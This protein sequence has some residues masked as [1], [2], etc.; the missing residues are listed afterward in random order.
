MIMQRFRILSIFLILA[1]LISLQTTA[2]RIVKNYEKEWVQVDAF[3]KR[4][5]PKSALTQVKK[6]Y[7]L[8]KKEKQ[9]AQIIK[10]LVYMTGLQEQVTENGGVNS[11]DDIEKEISTATEPAKSILNSMLADMYWNYYQQHR[12]QLYNR[13][14]TSAFRKDDIPTWTADDFHKRIS[15]L[16][17]QSVKN[18]SL[19]QET[20][21]NAYDAII[22]KG[23]VRHL[24]PTLFDLL[25]HRALNYF[26]ND[27]RDITRPAFAFEIDQDAA[28]DPAADF[29]HHKFITKDSLSLEYKALLLYQQLI[30]F[31][32]ND[33]RPD[34]LIDVDIERIEFVNEKGVQDNKKELYLAA[35]N[36]L[37]HQ[38]E[39]IPAASQALYLIAQQYNEDASNYQPYGDTTHRYDRIKAKEI[40]ERV[41]T[42][43]DS[44]E[45]KIN[46][47]NLLNEINKKDFKF[48]VE[49]VNI[50]NQP[51]R[52]LIQYRNFNPLYLRL[53]KADEKLKTDL[54]NYYDEK[55]WSKIVSA[56]A[57]R[58]W[59]QE[60]PGTNDLQ[61]HAVEIK[62]N[63]VPAGDYLLLAGTNK[64]FD[65]KNSVLG[66]RLFYV[67]NISYVNNGQNYF[68]LHRETGQPLVNAVVNIWEPKYDARASKNIKEKTSSYKT[69]E[70]GFFKLERKKEPSYGY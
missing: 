5:L 54:D 16:Y 59:E 37:A 11:L 41:L 21:L 33:A 20:N 62:I 14:N 3:V 53:I 43:K 7:L 58:S 8:A 67:S 48:S 38:Y 24:R 60:L 28:F 9:D 55:F 65:Q 23:N 51:F 44:S 22:V 64:N 69:D 45:G 68:V 17:L 50:P 12:W 2:Q 49:K 57:I 27:E 32:L 4:E 52:V 1:F 6:I 36:H 35:L 34:A 40:C 30:S 46:C 39:N 47:Y 42:Q 31:H 10:A 61:Q 13:T 15:D 25:A 19:L 18:A 26:K 70:K 63:P 29:I 66:A 56:T